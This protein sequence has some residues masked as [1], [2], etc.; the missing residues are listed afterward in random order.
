MNGFIELQSDAHTMGLHRN[1][2]LARAFQ[3]R[4]IATVNYF[5]LRAMND[6]NLM[7]F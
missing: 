2:F 4:I 3:K 6:I 5:Y 1:I 7:K